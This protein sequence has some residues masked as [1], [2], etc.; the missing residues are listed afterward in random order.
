MVLRF[1]LSSRAAG[2]TAASVVHIAA[3]LLLFSAAR[4][5]GTQHPHNGEGAQPG[6]LVVQLVPTAQI[7]PDS[8]PA[9]TVAPQSESRLDLAP[10]AVPDSRDRVQLAGALTPASAPAPSL[11]GSSAAPSSVST[12]G[13]VSGADAARFR[14]A[15]LAHILPFRRYPE[16]ARR[17]GAQTVVWVRFFLERDGT[18]VRVAVEQSSG[19]AVLDEAAITAIRRAAPLPTIPANLP[20][21]LDIS[22]PVDFAM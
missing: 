12:S 7:D 5:I 18:P 20:D 10:V 14:D 1:D 22:L 15:L 4:T 16:E 2:F 19:S 13:T 8:V 9:P 17:N 6:A 3:G 11:S 21:R